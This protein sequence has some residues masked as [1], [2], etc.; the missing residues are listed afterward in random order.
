[1][2]TQDDGVVVDPEPPEDWDDATLVGRSVSGDDQ[3]F[4]VLVRRYQAP[5]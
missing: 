2:L 5:L 1:V 3:A 4:A